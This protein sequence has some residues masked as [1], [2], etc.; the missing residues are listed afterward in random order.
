[1]WA[2]SG[3][4][5]KRLR[6]ERLARA[7][8]AGAKA[9]AIGLPWPKPAKGAGRPS[10]RKHWH[11]VLYASIIAGDELPDDVGLEPPAWWKREDG[12]SPPEAPPAEASEALDHVD[13]DPEPGHVE[14]DADP[15]PGHVEVSPM[16]K[17]KKVIL[18]PRLKNWFL[19]FAELQRARHGGDMQ[20]SLAEAKRLC[21]CFSQIHKDTPRRWQKLPSEPSVMG[22]PAVLSEAQIILLTGVVA[23]VTARVPLCA[24][25]I[26]DVME[27]ELDKIGVA[28]RPSIRWV[29]TFLVKAGAVIQAC[30]RVLAERARSRC[31]ARSTTELTTESATDT[32]QVRYRGRTRHQRRRNFAT[33]D[34]SQRDCLVREG[35]EDEAGAGWQIKHNRNAGSPYV[36]RAFILPAHLWRKNQ[37]SSSTRAS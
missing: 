1:M 31:E 11:D 8:A 10:A 24:S 6:E 18:D 20:R 35:R 15:E 21:P 23:K 19:C 9:L 2:V 14:V 16:K 34:S 32:A 7:G 33:Y 12:L 28:W 36:A 26:C 30:R 17:R 13:A 37:C 27:V 25:V 22:R 4:G 29:R 5:A 3:A